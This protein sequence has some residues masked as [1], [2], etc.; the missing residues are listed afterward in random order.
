MKQLTWKMEAHS[1]D[2]HSVNS[3]LFHANKAV[4]LQP[5]LIYLKD[6][7][8]GHPRKVKRSKKIFHLEMGGNL[9]RN[10]IHPERPAQEWMKSQEMQSAANCKH[11]AED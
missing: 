8:S 2:V 1:M 7:S 6:Q 10:T 3:S 4:Y 9:A 11:D 5:N